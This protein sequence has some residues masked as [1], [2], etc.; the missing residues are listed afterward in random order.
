MCFGPPLK[1]FPLEL[2]M[3]M[4]SRNQNDRATGP[5]EKFD[6]FF[7]HVD[8]IYQ[9]DGPTDGQTDTGPAKTALTHS[10]AW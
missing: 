4:G 8:T 6:D 2:G 9:R 1:G 7:S 5:R 10:V 3:H